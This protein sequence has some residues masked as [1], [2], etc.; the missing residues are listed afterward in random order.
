MPEQ[1]SPYGYTED[2]NCPRCG[3]ED[4]GMS[5][6]Y[7]DESEEYEMQDVYCEDCGAVLE[8]VETSDEQDP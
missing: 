4:Q 8:T 6:P 1:Q 3:S 5:S 2:D 7:Y